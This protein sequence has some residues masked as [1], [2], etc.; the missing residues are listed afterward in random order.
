MQFE[1]GVATLYKFYNV[2]LLGSVIMYTSLDRPKTAAWVVVVVVILHFIAGGGTWFFGGSKI[3]YTRYGLEQTMTFKHGMAIFNDFAVMP[4]AL[5][6]SMTSAL[7]ADKRWGQGA[8]A[9]GTTAAVFGNV[10]CNLLHAFP[11]QQDECIEEGQPHSTPK[12]RQ[13]QHL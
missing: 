4:F 10:V 3:L 8:Y 7:H 9:A 2:V 1:K 6:G 13:Q 5:A 12:Q 11:N